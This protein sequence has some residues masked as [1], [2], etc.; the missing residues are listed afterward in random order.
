MEMKTIL[1]VC[2]LVFL[3]FGIYTQCSI[4]EDFDWPR[5][6]GPKGD[7]ISMEIDW[8]PMAIENEP[9]IL[10][11]VDVGTGYSNVAI[12]DNRLYTMGGRTVFCFNSKTGKEIWQYSFE[13][14]SGAQSTPTIDDKYIYALNTNGVIVCLKGKNGKRVWRKELINDFNSPPSKYGFSSSPVIEGDLVII[15]AKTSGIALNKKTGDGVWEGE[16]HVDK[17]GNYYATPVLYDHNNRNYVL[18][19]SHTGL[20][21]MEVDTGKKLWFHEWTKYGSPNCV[22]PV[23][24]DEKVFI[25]SS[26]TD[27]R[28]TVLDISS[29]TPQVLWENNNLCNHFSTS[30][31][32]EGYLYGIDGDYHGNIKKCSLRCVDAETGNIVWKKDMM[33]ASL[34]A[35]DNKLII[36]EV[37]GTLH[38]A[39][40]TQ[41]AYREI[42]SCT[43]PTEIFHKWWTPP[44]LCN[45]KIYC[46]NYTGDLV[47]ID[48]SK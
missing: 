21:S 25:S 29:D 48:V 23:I 31:Y 33:G 7:G 37:D 15:N 32:V 4:A 17:S 1:L 28:G 24:F 19:F 5:W 20:Y 26:E 12:K 9:D 42:S 22:D 2:F 47:C 44:V 43:L 16:V 39:E 10:W 18:I 41:D 35:A 30:V 6:R 27:T 38:I 45:G 11:K 46:R 34:I 3:I 13:I 8:N 36:L 14:S 40:A